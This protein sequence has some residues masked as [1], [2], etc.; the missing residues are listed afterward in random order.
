[1]LIVTFP[2][3]DQRCKSE[4]G[5][6]QYRPQNNSFTDPSLKF[7][8]PSGAASVAQPSLLDGGPRCLLHLAALAH[9]KPTLLPLTLNPEPYRNFVRHG[10][11]VILQDPLLLDHD[12]PA[13]TRRPPSA[14]RITGETTPDVPD[15]LS[16]DQLNFV[17]PFLG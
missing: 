8:K 17:D 4:T 11:R 12:L 2:W 6:L 15:T 5:R 16:W 13:T 1:M 9:A 14:L 3:E 7:G 10:R